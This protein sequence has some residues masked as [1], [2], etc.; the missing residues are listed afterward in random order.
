M[1]GLRFKDVTYEDGPIV[2]NIRI[3]KNDPAA[4]RVKCFITNSNPI[5]GPHTWL[6]IYLNFVR[7]VPDDLLFQKVSTQ[8]ITEALR[9]RLAYLGIT[10][11]RYYSSHSFRKG[12]ATEA[13]RNGIQDSIIQRY[14]RWNSTCF[15]AYTLV[16]RH[17]GN[18]I[19]RVNLINHSIY[20]G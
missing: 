20:F 10:N 12:G 6:P 4:A 3:S 1:T 17:A 11:T 9:R 19:N 5:Y 14:G 16:Q 18:Q 2:L 13:S 8:S 15:M 7:N